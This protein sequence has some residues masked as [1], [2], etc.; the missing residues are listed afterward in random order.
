MNNNVLVLM[1]PNYMFM[2]WKNFN[3]WNVL[4]KDIKSLV[5]QHSWLPEGVHVK[6]KRSDDNFLSWWKGAKL[7]LVTTSQSVFGWIQ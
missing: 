2:Y 4:L 1:L 5:Q 6:R 7:P 3:T